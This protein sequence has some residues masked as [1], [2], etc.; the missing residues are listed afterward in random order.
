MRSDS[1]DPKRDLLR[2][3]VLISI[4]GWGEEVGKEGNFF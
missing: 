3:G 2:E 4:I 1:G